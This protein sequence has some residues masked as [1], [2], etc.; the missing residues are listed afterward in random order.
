MLN[1]FNHDKKNIMLLIVSPKS[2]R[3]L[4][5]S[6]IVVVLMITILVILV[7]IM[8]LVI[9]N[10]ITDFLM[11]IILL[12]ETITDNYSNSNIEHN[13]IDIVTVT[14]MAKIGIKPIM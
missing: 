7:V 9:M 10:V 6:C 5:V 3:Q 13:K 4:C 12:M 1:D 11:G 2:I 14:A 8:I